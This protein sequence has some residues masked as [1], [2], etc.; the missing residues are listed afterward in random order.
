[1]STGIVESFSLRNAYI[2]CFFVFGQLTWSM[3]VQT[4][5]CSKHQC[6]MPLHARY[7]APQSNYFRLLSAGCQRFESFV[8][9]LF[10]GPQAQI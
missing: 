4:M 6:N 1:M 9:I 2:P 8:P 7:H 10:G 3:H 5:S